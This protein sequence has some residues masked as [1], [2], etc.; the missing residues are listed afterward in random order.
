M[1]PDATAA[2]RNYAV[3]TAVREW[4]AI[5]AATLARV[6][7][8]YPDDRSRA[9]PVFRTLLF[10][11]ALVAA[12]AASGLA[13]AISSGT[14]VPVLMG[15]VLLVATELQVVAWRRADGGA[16]A[17]TAFLGVLLLVIGAAL[18]LET[19]YHPGELVL[20]RAALA[21]AAVVCWLAAGRWGFP[22]LAVLGCLACAALLATLPGGRALLLLL[23]LVAAAPLLR[24]TNARRFPPALRA[25]FAGALV[26]ALGAGYL[27]VNAWSLDGGW[28][29]SLGRQGRETGA[30]VRGAAALATALVPVLVLA[31]GAAR[32]SRLLLWA[33]A[34]MAVA[35]LATLRHF[36][37]LGPLWSW[38][39]AAGVLC[40]AVSLAV[41][42]ALAAAP[43]GERWGFTAEAWGRERRLEAAASTAAAMAVLTPE[44]KPAAP[45]P[46]FKPGGG[47]FGGGGAS[48]SY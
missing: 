19:S 11:F 25:A 24:A 34:A 18:V 30:W 17:A 46:S 22:F 6:D 42:R 5:D 15:A 8:L 20:A 33:G 43:G 37:P 44:A 3:R 41:R 13:F 28:I 35:S 10:A 2:D 27:A 14:W 7:A 29:E 12:A 1:R 23:P 40:V 21:L 48:D 32:R 38:L 45:E 36:F 47:G 31:L 16:E 9:R 39:A 26:V 4:A